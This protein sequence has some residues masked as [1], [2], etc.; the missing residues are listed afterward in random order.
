MVLRISIRGVYNAANSILERYVSTW[1][2][3]GCC[4]TSV[5]IHIAL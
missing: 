5:D 2:V 1:Y 3:E 4:E